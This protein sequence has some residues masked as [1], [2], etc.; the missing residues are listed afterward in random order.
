MTPLQPKQPSKV[1]VGFDG[2]VLSISLSR[3]KA[4]A[5][6]FGMLLPAGGGYLAG[7]TAEATEHAAGVPIA[8]VWRSSVW[9]DHLERGERQIQRLRDLEER[10]ER[11]DSALRRIEAALESRQHASDKPE[12][13]PAPMIVAAAV[14]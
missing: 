7:R 13:A 12:S 3:L 4:L 11:I 9:V 8:E 14:P 10:S 6:L 5:L 1:V 2:D